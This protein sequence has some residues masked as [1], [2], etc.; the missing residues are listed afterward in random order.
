MSQIMSNDVIKSYIKI[1]P[2]KDSSEID[3][4]IFPFDPMEKNR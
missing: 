1:V 4:V 2:S 3:G